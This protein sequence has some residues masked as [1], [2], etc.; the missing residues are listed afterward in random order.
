MDG[1]PG[2]KAF[3]SLLFLAG[4][5]SASDRTNQEARELFERLLALAKRSWAAGGG[6]RSAREA[7]ARKFSAS[8]YA[9]RAGEHR[10]R[11][12]RGERCAR[13][14]G[15]TA[16]WNAKDELIIKLHPEAPV[17][18]VEM[19]TGHEELVD[20]AIGGKRGATPQLG[21]AGHSRITLRYGA[22]DLGRIVTATED[23]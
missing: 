14:R 3:S 1:L 10:L 17:P 2:P 7:A 13:Q 23:R 15:D 18:T 20:R 5:L 11:A 21:R 8:I 4:G 6:I 22:A 9:R 12:F 16:Y 19:P